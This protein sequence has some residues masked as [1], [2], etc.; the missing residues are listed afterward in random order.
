M[1]IANARA[2]LSGRA[3]IL[4][5]LRVA[6]T[7]W[8]LLGDGDDALRSLRRRA[9]SGAAHSFA[10]VQRVVFSVKAEALRRDSVGLAGSPWTNSIDASVFG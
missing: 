4:E 8:G 7:I 1:A 2:S 6:A 5:D 9:F 10:L 3:P